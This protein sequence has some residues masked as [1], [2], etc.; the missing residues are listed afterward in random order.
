MPAPDKALSLIDRDEIVELSKQLIRV[1]SVTGDEKRVVLLARDM[2]EGLG[3]M[4]VPTSPR[5]M[6]CLSVWKSGCCLTVSNGPTTACCGS[7][8]TRS[9][10]AVTPPR[11]RR[12][13]HCSTSLTVVSG[14]S[15]SKSR[16][17]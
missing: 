13:L 11:Y 5:A 17:R 4:S 15:R 16:E 6:Y 8:G 10:I 1:P 7:S 9:S 3:V 14:I 12:P 2:I